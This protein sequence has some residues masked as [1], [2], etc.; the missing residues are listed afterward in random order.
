[1]RLKI[2]QK[3][4][5]SLNLPSYQELKEVITSI[6]PILS[7]EEPAKKLPFKEQQNQDTAKSSEMDHKSQQK[8]GTSQVSLNS[9]I[10]SSGD[11]NVPK[12][13]KLGPLYHPLHVSLLSLVEIENRHYAILQQTVKLL[14]SHV[15]QMLN[16]SLKSSVLAN[17][18]N[19]YKDILKVYDELNI[20][21][22]ALEKLFGFFESLLKALVLRSGKKKTSFNIF[23]RIL[24]AIEG[25][26]LPELKDDLEVIL[27]SSEQDTSQGDENVDGSHQDSSK[28]KTR[29]QKQP[30]KAHA[31]PYTG[32]MFL[33]NVKRKIR[34][35]DLLKEMKRKTELCEELRKMERQI[36]AGMEVDSPIIVMDEAN[37]KVA[38]DVCQI[39]IRFE[40]LV[41][42]ME[43]WRLEGA[44]EI[45]LRG[46]EEYLENIIQ[47]VGPVLGSV[48]GLNE[49]NRMGGRKA[50][51][52][53]DRLRRGMESMKNQPFEF[54]EFQEL[55][56]KVE[57][58]QEF[59]DRISK[60]VQSNV[61]IS[62]QFIALKNEY[63]DL[64]VKISV[65]DN[66]IKSYEEQKSVKS[67]IESQ[68]SVQSDSIWTTS[69]RNLLKI[70]NFNFV[71][72]A[73]LKAS[74]CQNMMSWL[75]HKLRQYVKKTSGKA[76]GE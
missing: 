31:S 11:Y 36:R 25:A 73:P 22:S 66:L 62:S 75:I 72:V 65:F 38:G 4:K 70:R 60:L 5:L 7:Q 53:L 74:L 76:D 17:L 50:V 10:C 57:K 32:L 28:G 56:K 26:E 20:R 49:Q 15:A 67:Y 6:L 34:K 8:L 37:E 45:E 48:I 55:K 14:H 2:V 39:R 46:T 58:A 42:L 23:E 63:F 54:L 16:L 64:E 68:K 29:S 1:M 30:K 33:E 18:S 3:E 59:E 24:D 47:K 71:N 35:S 51:E 52:S 40:D 41:R 19:T 61:N 44:G 12:P 9:R 21:S 13:S 27:P 69:Y 43:R